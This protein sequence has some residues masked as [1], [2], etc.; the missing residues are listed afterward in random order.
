MII[1]AEVFP[2]V[3]TVDCCQEYSRRVKN[4]EVLLVL[5][6]IEQTSKSMYKY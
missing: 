1:L 6:N 5:L 2:D 4:T 3:N